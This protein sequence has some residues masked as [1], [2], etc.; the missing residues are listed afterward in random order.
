[1][2]LA[3]AVLWPG[4]A[5]DRLQSS[6]VMP[7]TVLVSCTAR[8]KSSPGW[9]PVVEKVTGLCGVPFHVSVAVMVAGSDEELSV[10]NVACTIGSTLTIDEL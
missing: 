1:M 3:V 4:I 5:T 6:R 2:P 10:I 7:V 8:V 9:K